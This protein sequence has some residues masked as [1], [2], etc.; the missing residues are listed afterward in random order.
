M[1]ESRQG[2][3]DHGW[4]WRCVQ[5]TILGWKETVWVWSSRHSAAITAFLVSGGYDVLVIV[6]HF[7]NASKSV[8]TRREE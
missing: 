7:T 8:T 6:K 5:P 2:A 4:G 1:P 3:W